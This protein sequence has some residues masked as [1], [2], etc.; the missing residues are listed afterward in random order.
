MQQ[1]CVFVLEEETD[2]DVTVIPE[3][4]YCDVLAQ[5]MHHVLQ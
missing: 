2:A 4:D 1:I 3:T 5:S